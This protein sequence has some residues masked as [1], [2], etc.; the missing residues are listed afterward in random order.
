MASD[1]MPSFLSIVAS[2]SRR[3]AKMP[4]S[5]VGT[6]TSWSLEDA[7]RELTSLEAILVASSFS[8]AVNGLCGSLAGPASVMSSSGWPCCF[9]IS[10]TILTSVLSP[11]KRS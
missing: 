2:N 4:V 8:C 10:Q 9:S 11:G 6:K 7:S 1:S 3:R 5:F